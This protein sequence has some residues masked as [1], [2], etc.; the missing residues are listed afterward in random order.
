LN[1]NFISGPNRKYRLRY[2]AHTVAKLD[3]DGLHS[4]CDYRAAPDE[5]LSLL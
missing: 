1:S 3:G 2:S 4:R 5:L